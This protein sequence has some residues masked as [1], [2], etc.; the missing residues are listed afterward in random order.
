VPS[1][2]ATPWLATK[3]FNTPSARSNNF[4]MIP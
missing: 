3:T 4:I 2:I 1:Q